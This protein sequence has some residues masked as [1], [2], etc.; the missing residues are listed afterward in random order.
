MRRGWVV[1]FGLVASLIVA[2]N[3]A[4]FP[5]AMQHLESAAASASVP[6]PQRIPLP[7]GF[8][9]PPGSAPQAM[10]NEDPGLIGLWT[11]DAGGSAAYNFFLQALPAAGF[12]ISGAYAGDTVAQFL[13]T[14]PGGATL[15]I[16]LSSTKA[17]TTRIGV[18]LPR[19]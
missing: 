4:P 15:Q 6:A 19:P 13:F 17:L 1:A 18:R 16:D 2:C 10:P 8:P 9:L 14:I 12:P 5:S 7:P 11:I 3:R